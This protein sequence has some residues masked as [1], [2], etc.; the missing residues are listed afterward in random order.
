MS[1]AADMREM[2]EER[3]EVH[4]PGPDPVQ[5]RKM[6]QNVLNAFNMQVETFH[7]GLNYSNHK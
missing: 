6:E 1:G 3:Q 7:I 4:A 5:D 2:L